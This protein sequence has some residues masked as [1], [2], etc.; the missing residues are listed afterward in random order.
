[1]VSKVGGILHHRFV[2]CRSGGHWGN[3]EQVVARWRHLMAFIKV[4][5]LLHKTML[6]VVH[7][8]TAMAI[9]MTSDGGTF[10][11]VAASFV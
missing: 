6:V 10:F 9:K 1:M 3:T 7:H 5:D 8:R 4:L 2:C 11:A